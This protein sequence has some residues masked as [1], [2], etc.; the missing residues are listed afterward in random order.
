MGE[1]SKLYY[2]VINT[3]R[4]AIKTQSVRVKEKRSRAGSRRVL[5]KK[6]KVNVTVQS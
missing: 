4:L 5:L 1:K 3:R 2:Y 6:R